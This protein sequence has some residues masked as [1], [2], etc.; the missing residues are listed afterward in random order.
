[1][2]TEDYGCQIQIQV[3]LKEASSVLFVF[4]ADEDL[5]EGIKK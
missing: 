5:S 4:I 1:M 2:S 3:D